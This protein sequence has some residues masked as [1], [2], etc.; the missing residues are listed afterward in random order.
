MTPPLIIPSSRW[1]LWNSL[2]MDPVVQIMHEV[3]VHATIHERD[4]K[5]RRLEIQ[6]DGSYVFSWPTRVSD[7]IFRHT[8][9]KEQ[10][11]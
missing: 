4:I 8:Y 10:D 7:I 3:E 6:P 11:R 2:K 9:R 5:E 1:E